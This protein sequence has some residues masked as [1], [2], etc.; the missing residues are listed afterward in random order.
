M[1]TLF[2]Q[3]PLN[4][5][6]EWLTPPH[7]IK[8]LGPFDLDPCSPIDRPW[9][10]AA[11]HLT[12]NDNGLTATWFGRVWCNP[13]YS[14]IGTWLKKCVYHGNAVSLVFARTETAA[15]FRYVWN[16]ADSVFFFANRLQF[17]HVS[18]VSSLRNAGAPSVLIAYGR[19]NVEAIEDSGLKGK[20]VHINSTPI[21][22]VGISPT[23]IQ[24]VTIAVKHY[25]DD[26]LRPLY[27]MVE[28]IAPDKVA[29]NQHW[30]AKI[31]QSIQ[32]IRK[33]QPGE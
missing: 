6:D 5:K 10:T 30:K 21:I 24:V 8:A 15:F 28:R 27:E 29:K 33:R 4:R 12:E 17:H 1:N 3:S 7:I 18:G 31:R 2:E 20:H 32:F 19:N 16:K 26:E 14:D 11:H 9:P 13:P 23:W 22:V 25:G